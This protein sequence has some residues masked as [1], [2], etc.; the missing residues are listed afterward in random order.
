MWNWWRKK[1]ITDGEI[2]LN[3]TLTSKD[4]NPEGWGTTFLYDI[5][6]VKTKR[7]VGRCDLRVGD[8]HTLYIGGNIGYSIYIPYRGHHYAAKAC[9]LLFGVA[10][11][12]GM[13]QVI[14][15]CNPDNIASY[16]TC[17]ICGCIM[18]EIVDVPVNHEL[19][20]QGD[21]QKCIFVKELI[22]T[23]DRNA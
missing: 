11:Q 22:E 4:P 16:R 19:Y 10:K 2:E 17:E 14:I 12:I 5:T 1:K 21:R 18:K 23:Q 8:S 20:L 7:T 13:T 15:T 3:L 6:E 9:D